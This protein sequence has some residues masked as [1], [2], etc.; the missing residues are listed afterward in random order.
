MYTSNQNNTTVLGREP[1]FKLEQEMRLRNF[2][3][4]TIKSYLYYNKELLRFASHKSPIKIIR[5]DIKDYLDFLI[6][7]SKS[8]S[9]IDL[10]INALKFYYST[11]LERKFF[12]NNKIKRPKKDKTLPIVLSKEEIKRMIDNIDN[13]K[14]R[15]MAVLLYSSGLRVSELVGLRMNNIDTQRKTIHIRAGK[16]RKDRI[17]VLSRKAIELIDQYL[18]EYQPLEYIFESYQPGKKISTRTVQLVVAEAGQKVGIKK[19]IGPH[20]LRHSFATHMLENGVNLRYIQSMLGHKRL[21]TTQ[22][23]TQVATDK[24]IGINDLLDY[25]TNN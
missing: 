20:T 17:T 24:F 18:F 14:H 5:Q 7:N 19:T 16:G 12:V 4:K 2:S 6:S 25:E 3:P 23:Y 22:I 1:L 11:I 10:A 13:L 9:T 21:E 8:R 15:L